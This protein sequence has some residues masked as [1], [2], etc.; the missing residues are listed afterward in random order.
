MVKDNNGS[1]PSEERALKLEK[2]D[3]KESKETPKPSKA[4][5]R[6]R[7]KPEEVS[8]L[9]QMRGELHSQFQVAKR[10]MALWE[11]VSRGLLADGIN[12]SPGQCK[13]RWASLVQEY[14]VCYS[15]AFCGLSLHF[16]FLL[17]FSICIGNFSSY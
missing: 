17:S 13:S 8:K 3:S 4:I 7:W 15:W 11:E 6:N 2:N 10:R 1:I 16:C 12:R 5:K 14:E 9:I